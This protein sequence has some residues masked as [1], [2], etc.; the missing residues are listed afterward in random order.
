MKL[1]L[2]LSVIAVFIL[3]AC[4]SNKDA[5]P[6]PV[7]SVPQLISIQGGTI[8]MKASDPYQKVESSTVLTDQIKPINDGTK[9][10]LVADTVK[11][12]SDNVNWVSELIVNSEGGKFNFYVKPHTMA[13]LYRVNAYPVASENI[14]FD[15]GLNARFF[16]NV[17]AGDPL[18]LGLIKTNSFEDLVS[19][20]NLKNLNESWIL[21][22]NPDTISYIV[23]GPISD[24]YENLLEE[25]TINLTVDQGNIIS[26]NP[27]RVISGYSYFSYKSD[28]IISSFNTTASISHTS[29]IILTKN[30]SIKKTSPQL[31]F[32]NN[33]DF[34]S[35][36]TGE[37][38]CQS[39][40]LK[41]TG[42]MLATNLELSSTFPFSL[43]DESVSDPLCIVT[44]DT[45]KQHQSLRSGESCLARIKF[46]QPSS[47]VVDGELVAQMS[48][49]EFSGALAIQK[50]R[51]QA[52]QAAALVS[53]N[54]FV[55]FG[56][57]QCS[58][59]RTVDIV[60]T[61]TG[62]FNATGITVQ[63]PP[64]NNNQTNPFYSIIL[65][66]VDAPMSNNLSSIA[67]C[68]TTFPPNRKCRV[69]VKFNP[70]AGIKNQALI[71]QI[72]G[73]NINPLILTVSGYTVP[74]QAL[75]TFPISFITPNNSILPL[76]M[77]LQSSQ[78]TRVDVGPIVD[79]CNK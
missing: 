29:G 9:F 67:N 66:P 8:R 13:G 51:T 58:S 42:S 41:N 74:G 3:S 5:A 60:V 36:T 45:C 23:V 31:F 10:R 11:I 20:D 34:T 59:S 57:T 77:Y 12:S 52:V 65:P 14:K 54:A 44:N 16:I 61:N 53:A 2:W 47:S 33:P 79:A 70:S 48:P 1:S 22:S 32:L 71:G 30:E 49:Q 63:N 72:L 43:V 15:Q 25:G 73:A 24:S 6:V 62:D 37:T 18:T 50:L 76:G 78:R 55:S 46:S 17:V 75:N 21:S 7:L 28:G 4:T 64:P 39:V 38:R 56:G 19:Y 27:T 35:M 68:G 40:R 69:Q 26:E